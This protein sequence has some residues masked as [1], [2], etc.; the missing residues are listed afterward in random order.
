[1][2][3]FPISGRLQVLNSA[4]IEVR[5]KWVEMRSKIYLNYIGARQYQFNLLVVHA[6]I[7]LFWDCPLKKDLA[8]LQIVTTIFFK[9]MFKRE[10]ASKFELTY[11][12]DS[13][14]KLNDS[15]EQHSSNH[16]TNE[17]KGKKAD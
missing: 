3:P 4:S 2:L 15:H 1:M 10:L 7:H 9:Q 5:E 11:C 14:L 6:M 8:L 17:L 12:D 16:A 13:F